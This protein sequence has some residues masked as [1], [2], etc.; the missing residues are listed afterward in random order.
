VARTGGFKIADAYVEISLDRSNLDRD[1]ADIPRQA[2]P[3]ADRAGN[4]LGEKLD[5]G[6]SQ[7]VRRSR[8]LS[9]DVEDAGR[10]AAPAAD[11]AGRGVGDKISQGLSMSV[12]RNSPLIVA[13][14]AAALAAGGPVM[15]T[16][17]TAMF[18]G[19][20][21][22]A[23]AQSQRVQSAWLGTWSTIKTGAI[24]DARVMEGALVGAADQVGDGFERMRPRLRDAFSAA[25]PQV[26]VFTQGV[27]SLA[28]NAL[29][30]LVRAVERGMPVTMGFASFLGSTGTGLTNFF[31][32]ISSHSPA[33]GTAFDALG[34]I[35]AALLPILGELLGQGAELAAVVLPPV[36][37]ILEVVARALASVGDV[38]PIVAMGFGALK[39]GSGLT[40]MFEGLTTRLTA[41]AAAGGALSTVSGSLA[42]GMGRVASVAG[43]LGIALAAIALAY[44][45]GKQEAREFGQAM[46]DGG[47]A[48]QDA[49][50]QAAANDVT[51]KL[52]QGFPLLSAAFN[53]F[54]S[55]TKEAKAASRD[56]FASMNDGEQAAQ[57]VK[58]RTNE[59]ADAVSEYG[60][61]SP[62][63]RSAA[64]A[65]T[66]AQREQERANGELETAIH[67]VT[68][69]MVEQTN[70]AMAAVD[71]GFAYQNSLNQL[72]DA[73]AALAEAQAHVNDTNEDT[74]T[75]SEDVARAQLAVAEQAYATAQAFGQQ[76]A[77]MSG[78][79]SG[80][81]EYTRILQQQ[82]L[83]RLYELRDAA[84]PELAA[85][86]S[87]QISML[88]AS[89]V[90]LQETGAAA[91]AVT[92][93]MQGMGLSVQQVPGYKGVIIDAPTD[94]Q[95]RR[96]E[97]LGY[98]I[99]T[100]PD[101]SVYVVAN[102]ADAQREINAL[103]ATRT[104]K[105]VAQAVGN[106][107][108][109]R[110]TGGS[111]GRGLSVGGKV[112]GPG[113]P[114]DDAVGPFPTVRGDTWLSDDEWV[115][116]AAS[117]NHYGNVLMK[118]VN[119]GTARISLPGRGRA[120]GGSVGGALPAGLLEQLIPAG[121]YR[122]LTDSV[123]AGVADSV[124]DSAP[125]LT[126]AMLASLPPVTAAVQAAT[127]D[128]WSAVSAAAPALMAG[129]QQAS[130]A[131]HAAVVAAAPSLTN[132][133]VVG[134]G[135]ISEQLRQ[136]LSA[137]QP[138]AATGTGGGASDL[139]RGAQEILN[140]WRGGAKLYEDFSY[141][142]MNSVGGI[143][144]RMQDQ[145]ADLYYAQG[146]AFPDSR[147]VE[148]FLTGLAGRA[149]GGWTP[150]GV[151]AVG[152]EG[153]E[154]L[155]VPRAGYVSSA[156]ET[157]A[158]LAGARAGEGG[159]TI[160]V[161]EVNVRGT[162]DFTDPAATRRAAQAFREAL[163][164]LEREQS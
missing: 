57:M 135:Q 11:R 78:A 26:N 33:A 13:G 85:S 128:L 28:E 43:P 95:R 102:T 139:A 10:R 64:E 41:N 155:T 35:I 86:L 112:D 49:A 117:A 62:A 127:P 146:G 92:Q 160:H 42:G 87:Q 149:R 21:I 47:Q 99:V 56:L 142:G 156:D 60:A 110:A 63:A 132:A 15:L 51:G 39:V 157:R 116:K 5:G 120:G 154:L 53:L 18:A 37:S 144:G 70:Q 6:M 134:G 131:L 29:P 97:D 14:I 106:L 122:R 7:A 98:R 81:E 58:L 34:R 3:A 136:T 66:A 31:D 30:G 158:L 150:P 68:A 54:T 61:N 71:S 73:Q 44:Q 103:T 105:I 108:P 114:T 118:A 91:A 126:Q 115:I 133:I 48:A 72:E 4:E 148:A 93:R 9:G 55:D 119:D 121:F 125:L 124:D 67:G 151:Y 1:I 159:T 50:Q 19:I 25:T 138:S 145:I 76:Q 129:V 77:D 20:G 94:D 79:K 45:H 100:L 161:A 27:L 16:A 141:A 46:L 123:G 75:S 83:Q 22:L 32:A 36:A 152:E 84:G 143:G 111:V 130:P 38:L 74:R 80:T 89:G 12:V 59:L 164:A 163:I 65:L 153:P 107:N 52:L 69:A 96:I 162:F 109:F 17:A 88:E 2:G 104:V 113:G 24:Q 137:G 90:S 82:T 147:R 40:S 23:A 8:R 101:G 140:A